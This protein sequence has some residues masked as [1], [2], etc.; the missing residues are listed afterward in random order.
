MRG[1]EDAAEIPIVHEGVDFVVVDKPAG[2]FTHRTKLDARLPGLVEVMREQLGRHVHTV[3]RL[4]R[5]VSGLL[6]VAF[7]AR[8]CARLQAAMQDDGAVKEYIAL[9]RGRS[10]PRF[11]C[12]EA[13]KNA[14]GKLQDART[15]FRTL[16]HFPWCSLVAARIHTGR[17]HQI[18]RHC[19]RV[20]HH[21]LG[22]R[23]YGKSRLNDLYRERY[24]LHRPFLHA[25]RLSLPSEGLELR[26]GLPREL[27][28]VVRGLERDAQSQL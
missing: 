28:S 4:D 11:A 18:R 17:R 5:P 16:R 20:Q 6:V 1:V 8:A 24:K 12:D 3:H 15:S 19:D 21:I 2:L 10:A 7:D 13:L 22:D 14:A 23:S 9:V 27:C 25:R 26:L